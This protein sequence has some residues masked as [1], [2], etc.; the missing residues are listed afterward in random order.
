MIRVEVAGT[1]Q[2]LKDVYNIRRQVFI[3]EQGVPEEIEVDDQEKASI[4]FVAYEEERPVGAGR[5]RVMDLTAKAER[6]C[7]LSDDRSRGIGA[8]IINKME[9]VARENELELLKLNSQ[10]QAEDFY[11]RLGYET[12]SDTFYDANILHVTMQKQL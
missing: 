1:E 2:Q 12:V 9:E 7:V 3:V 6:V 10:I 8:L 5:M 11:K 4:H